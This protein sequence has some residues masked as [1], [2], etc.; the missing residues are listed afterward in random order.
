MIGGAL[1]RFCSS[2]IRHLPDMSQQEYNMTEMYELNDAELDAVAA[3]AG[4]GAGAGGLVAVAAAVA[5]DQINV[6]NDALNDN[7]VPVLSGNTITVENVANHNNVGLGV[8]IN[9][10][11]G[12]AAIRS[13]QTQ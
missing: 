7:F 3:G 12:P 2:G 6:L 10:L 1:A 13:L 8:L 9:A 5:V 11:G 4:A